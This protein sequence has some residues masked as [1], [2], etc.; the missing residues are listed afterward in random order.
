MSW[1][2]CISVERFESIRLD[3]C[4]ETWSTLRFFR[5][6]DASVVDGFMINQTEPF[7]LS[8]RA[9]FFGCLHEKL[10]ES[11]ARSFF[12]ST[13]VA[14][15]FSFIYFHSHPPLSH[16]PFFLQH[17][18]G[19][20]RLVFFALIHK[21]QSP[22]I[23]QRFLAP[24]HPKMSHRDWESESKRRAVRP[25]QYFSYFISPYILIYYTILLFQYV[26]VE[27]FASL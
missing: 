23:I 20:R 3:C 15:W 1:M 16:S 24:W 18:A 19:S 11:G 8:R 4:D 26:A 25:G 7:P 12:G 9:F 14:M 5:K 13:C 21:Q 17:S 10:P 27:C 6:L 2:L 22:M